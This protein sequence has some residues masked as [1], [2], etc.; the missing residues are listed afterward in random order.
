MTEGECGDNL[1]LDGLVFLSFAVKGIHD[2][3]RPP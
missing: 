3:I 2:M 1:K